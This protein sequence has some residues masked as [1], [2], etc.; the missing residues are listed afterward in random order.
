[1]TTSAE[2]R[3]RERIALPLLTVMYV[4]VPLVFLAL[5]VIVE[6]H[7]STDSE[8][9]FDWIQVIPSTIMLATGVFLL[10][11]R[12]YTLAKWA[13]GGGLFGAIGGFFVFGIISIQAIGLDGEFFDKLSYSFVFAAPL[14]GGICWLLGHSARRVLTYPVVAELA[15]SPYVW[16]F[17]VRD[18]RRVTVGIDM[19]HLSIMET[20]S[21]GSGDNATTRSRG[22]RIALAHLSEIGA[23]TVDG[24]MPPQLPSAIQSQVDTAPGPALVI[25]RGKARLVVPVDEA[26][27]IAQLIQRRIS[28]A[29]TEQPR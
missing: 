10:R 29:R 15:D 4:G 26:D 24:A 13:G 11:R 5:A 2:V 8:R 23:V 25:P 28:L 6:Q 19:R 12:R 18:A 22:E 17:R 27:S 7:N 21:V 1:M 20:Y 14:F 3:R 16:T 9:G